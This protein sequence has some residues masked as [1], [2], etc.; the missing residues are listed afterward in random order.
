M[1]SNELTFDLVHSFLLDNGGKVRNRE[2]VRYFRNYLTDP[3][4]KGKFRLLISL[5]LIRNS[6]C[7][8]TVSVKQPVE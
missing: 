7:L 4:S 5:N 1:A 3:V 2:A 8:Q 6:F